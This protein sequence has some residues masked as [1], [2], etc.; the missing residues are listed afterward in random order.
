M[1]SGT[2]ARHT[3]PRR[4]SSTAPAGLGRSVAPLG[5]AQVGTA[6]AQAGFT[7]EIIQPIPR[8][9]IVHH[10]LDDGS[11][12]VTHGRRIERIGEERQRLGCFPFAA[13][14][15]FF[16]FPRLAQRAA[17]A[18]KCNL[19]PNSQGRL[20]GMRANVVSTIR[21]GRVEPLFRV[22][23]DS[24][25]HGGLCEDAE[26]W[27]Y[28]GEYFM[29]PRRQPVKVWRVS[30]D[31]TRWEVAYEFPAGRTRHVHTI[32]RDPY[33][34]GALWATLGDFAGE[35]CLVRTDDR[36]RT[37]E[38]LGDGSQHWRAVSLFFT[39]EHVCWLTDSHL[40]QNHACRMRRGSG[41]LEIG[42][43]VE[44]SAWYGAK[45]TEGLY[46]AFTTVEPGEAIQSRYASVLVSRD[47]FRWTPVYRFKKDIYRPYRVFKFGVIGC[48][49]GT[50]S[51]SDFVI[52]GEGL[53]GFDG[54]AVRMR[55]AEGAE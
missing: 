42:Q 6:P 5:A 7:A 32:A 8:A 23:G 13:P 20:L 35:C 17:R 36:F 4:V 22:N 39:P 43:P 11:L 24:V 34:P 1:I 53:S 33:E 15:D 49:A 37:V 47:A 55:I 52:F 45:T 18:D 50:Q 19:F 27:T 28:F 29:N 26:G 21:D 51:A 30:P 54:R 46:V 12:L 2:D 25:L 3:I 16:S 48:P 38:F 31:H 44:C 40:H 41:D 10:V 14:R 9:T